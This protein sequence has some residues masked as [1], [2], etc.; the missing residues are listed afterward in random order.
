MRLGVPA[1]AEAALQCWAERK[2]IPRSGSIFAS[3]LK[4]RVR[5]NRRRGKLVLIGV[6][7]SI[8]YKSVHFSDPAVDCPSSSTAR[9]AHHHCY[10]SQLQRTRSHLCASAAHRHGASSAADPIVPKPKA[11][12]PKSSYP[13]RRTSEAPEQAGK[14]PLK[15]AAGQ[16]RNLA[17][18]KV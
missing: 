1:V 14:H 8:E 5:G 18:A 13:P 11:P 9:G 7:G 17:P 10:R 3:T 16:T 15:C 4:R 2:K 6:V 12:P